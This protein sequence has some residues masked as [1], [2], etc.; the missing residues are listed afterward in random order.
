M[1]VICARGVLLLYL[2]MYR[3]MD[4]V[5]DLYL[6]RYTYRYMHKHMHKHKHE[7]EHEHK[8]HSTPKPPKQSAPLMTQPSRCTHL[9]RS[10]CICICVQA[11][12]TEIDHRSE[13][14]DCIVQGISNKCFPCP[15][16][17]RYVFCSIS[18]AGSTKW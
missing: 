18:Q 8:K 14:G 7:H 4:Q 5:P 10:A 9:L 13:I 12:C 2:Y 17:Y 1:V 16:M 11:T 6:S 15:Y 3:D